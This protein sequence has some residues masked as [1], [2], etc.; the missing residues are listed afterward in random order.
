MGGRR[1]TAANRIAAEGS[2][3]AVAKVN[4]W[5]VSVMY[6]KQTSLSRVIRV[7]WRRG[8]RRGSGGGDSEVRG[9]G[10]EAGGVDGGRVVRYQGSTARS[11]GGAVETA[12]SAPSRLHGRLAMGAARVFCGGAIQKTAGCEGRFRHRT[13]AREI[14]LEHASED[15]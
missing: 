13:A 5:E 6:S 12:M 4:L 3:T 2:T 9:G 11:G 14:L 8:R 10:G 7:W 1:V 15:R